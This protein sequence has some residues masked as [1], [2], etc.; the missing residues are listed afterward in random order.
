MPPKR[1]Q[2]FYPA[3]R[4]PYAPDNSSFEPVKSQPIYGMFGDLW[5]QK[6]GPVTDAEYVSSLYDAEIRHADDGI[7]ATAC[8][9]GRNRTWRTIRLSF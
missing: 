1:Y 6:L 3:D 8:H 4:D 2:T 9:A 7:A 5:F